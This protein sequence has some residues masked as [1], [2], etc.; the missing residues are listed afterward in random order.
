MSLMILGV[1]FFAVAVWM[2]NTGFLWK[3]LWSVG[4]L[5]SVMFFLSRFD[6]MFMLQIGRPLPGVVGYLGA[7]SL[8]M[9][10]LLGFTQRAWLPR[11]RAVAP[12]IGGWSVLA[13]ISGA[14]NGGGDGG[15]A[16]DAVPDRKALKQA[17]G[18]VHNIVR[19]FLGDFF[20]SKW[21][22]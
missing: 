17:R 19:V 14:P 3:D 16:A 18:H 2:L 15:T 10:F 6:A 7:V 13:L 20:F 8:I 9:M 4:L 1:V 21:N 11:L 12:W 5:M 22:K